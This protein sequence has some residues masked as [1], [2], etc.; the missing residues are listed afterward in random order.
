MSSRDLSRLPLPLP[1]GAQEEVPEPLS[2][3]E[4]RRQ[5]Y[6]SP[7]LYEY[8]PPPRWVQKILLWFVAWAMNMVIGPRKARFP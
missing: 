3:E 4:L 5:G 7:E 1:I 6:E 2:N 8:A